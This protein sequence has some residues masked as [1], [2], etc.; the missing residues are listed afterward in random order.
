MNAPQLQA[1]LR[2][3]GIE[4]EIT[5]SG[6]IAILRVAADDRVLAE[7]ETRR[8]AVALAAEHGFRSLALEVA[9]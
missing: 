8:A 6:V 3:L 4:G 2:T 7:A 5:A 1:A 9:D